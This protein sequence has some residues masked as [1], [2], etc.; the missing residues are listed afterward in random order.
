MTA[1]DNLL[2]GRVSQILRR[3]NNFQLVKMNIK[4]K[5]YIYW[6]YTS[7]VITH[8]K[9]IV[10][11]MTPYQRTCLKKVFENFTTVTIFSKQKKKRNNN[12]R[13][14]L[15]RIFHHQFSEAPNEINNS[16]QTL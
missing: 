3:L 2:N 16:N 14:E 10:E 11:R 6:K 12:N 5:C 13:K 1:N 8:V 9:R 7:K 4:R 15:V